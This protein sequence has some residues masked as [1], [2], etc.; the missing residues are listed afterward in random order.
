MD[1]ISAGFRAHP[2]AKNILSGG[3]GGEHKRNADVVFV[4][5]HASVH[6]CSLRVAH[7]CQAAAPRNQSWLWWRRGCVRRRCGRSS[8]SR[9]GEGAMEDSPTGAGEGGPTEF[10]LGAASCCDSEARG[11]KYERSR[12]AFAVVAGRA[13]FLDTRPGPLPISWGPPKCRS[14]CRPACFR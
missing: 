3:T 4:N 8:A 9:T 7:R 6:H 10:A 14:H 2:G 12:I 5:L 11:D 1:A 13:I